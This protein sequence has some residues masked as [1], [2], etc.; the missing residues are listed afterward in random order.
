M[1]AVSVVISELYGSIGGSLLEA[2]YASQKDIT[3]QRT[4]NFIDPEKVGY[5]KDHKETCNG[6]PKQW[7]EKSFKTEIKKLVYL[8]LEQM[9][10]A[11]ILV[12]S[13]GNDYPPEL[14]G[15]KRHEKT[16]AINIFD[17][18]DVI[19]SYRI[20]YAIANG[21]PIHG[22]CR[23]HQMT[24]VNMLSIFSD[25]PIKF[26][27]HIPNFLE[28]HS[29][30]KHAEQH[31]FGEF[32]HKKTEITGQDRWL[33]KLVIAEKRKEVPVFKNYKGGK[34]F[35]AITRDCLLKD[36]VKVAKKSKAGRDDIIISDDR[37]IFSV[38]DSHH[39]AFGFKNIDEFKKFKKQLA[40]AGGRIDA[41]SANPEDKFVEMIEAISFSKKITPK[42][43]KK[44]EKRVDELNKIFGLDI[45]VKMPDFTNGKYPRFEATTIQSHPEINIGGTALVTPAILAKFVRDR[46]SILE[47][48]GVSIK[49][50]QW[51]ATKTEKDFADIVKYSIKSTRSVS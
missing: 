13:G 26:K 43:V 50:N 24:T 22:I 44:I 32:A 40:K 35:A 3:V 1:I 49:Y 21:I 18:S 19:E 48:A 11:K 7:Q 5:P 41:I 46:D 39:Q 28:K 4:N 42:V 34:S 36:A 17:V 8:A 15:K 20:S 47:E 9:K 23:G 10:D 16:D 6:I 38:A 14:Y 51:R 29:G 12:L 45:E 25:D 33:E 2:S 30:K 27:Q 37:T 31:K